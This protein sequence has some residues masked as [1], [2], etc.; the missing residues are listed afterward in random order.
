[1]SLFTIKNAILYIIILIIVTL[2]LIL[3]N[4]S[5]GGGLV[6]A[7]RTTETEQNDVLPD[8]YI[9]NKTYTEIIDRNNGRAC[10]ECHSEF[11]P[12]KLTVDI[13]NSIRPGEA[14]EYRIIVTNSDR[15]TEHSVEDLEATLTGIG[16]E[17]KEPYNN[18]LSGSIRR[19]GLV[20]YNFPVEAGASSVL[21]SV[22]GNSGIGGLNDIDLRLSSPSGREWSSSSGGVTEEIELELQSIQDGGYGDY[23]IE[24]SYVSGLGAISYSLSIDVDYLA[25][26]LLQSGSNLKPGEKYEF[27][28]TLILTAEE[29]DNLGGIVSGTV[30]YAHEDGESETYRYQ[31]EISSDLVIGTSG[32]IGINPNLTFGR[33]I[34]LFSLLMLAGVLLTSYSESS[35]RFLAGIL[36]MKNPR[37]I[38]CYVSVSILFVALIHASLLLVSNY[39][40]TAAPSIVGSIAFI[41]FLIMSVEGFNRD[42]IIAGIGKQKWKRLH[43]VL[44]ASIVLIV[45]YHAFVFGNH[46]LG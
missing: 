6:D 25:K 46:F 26:E 10:E 15:D 41:L 43:L 1:M 8:T 44:A 37:R 38:H 14:F 12:F 9:D 29:I 27:A 32:D 4:N 17:P 30:S 16:A 36:K 28:W 18:E 7:L 23:R 33:Y 3:I 24:I 22:S 39:T 40:I 42:R 20:T 45:L 2:L 11:Y 13:G 31:L 21:V 34:G 19:F 5:F 35:R